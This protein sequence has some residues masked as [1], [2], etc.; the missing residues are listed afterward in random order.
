MADIDN[1]AGLYTIRLTWAD[2]AFHVTSQ[3]NGEA[4]PST[5]VCCDAVRGNRERG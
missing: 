5:Y 4:L 1:G 2:T 3:P